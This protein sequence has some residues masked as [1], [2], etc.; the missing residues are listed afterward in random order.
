MS[1]QN[2]ENPSL[3]AVP[4]NLKNKNN[5]EIYNLF[6]LSVGDTMGL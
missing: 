6:R 1:L 2:K 3:L 5:E 4:E